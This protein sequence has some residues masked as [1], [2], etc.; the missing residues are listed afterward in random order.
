MKKRTIGD[1][2][3]SALGLGCM[4][5][6]VAY[7]PPADEADM[8]R[9]MR[10]AHDQGVTFFDTAEAY[11]PFANE[12]LVGKALAPIR[13]Q[14]VIATKF[15][16]DIDQQTG[17]RSG[18]T[19][20]RPDHVKAVADACLRRLKTDRIDLF[21]Q[22]RVDPDVPIEDVAGAV[23]ELIAAGK[24]KYFGLSEAGVQTI[25]RAHAVQKVTAVQSEYSLF[26]RGPEAELLPTLQELGIGFVPFSPLGAGFLTGK[27][28]ENTKF[29]PSDFR[30]SVPRFS[31]EARKANFA[32]VDL[33]RRI[34]D[35]KGATPAQI[36]LSWLLSQKPWIVPI[37]GTTKQ[38]RLEENL[39]AVDVDLLPEDLAEIDAALSEIE[40][41]GERLPEAALK[42]TGR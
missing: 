17:E 9:L 25:R 20:S 13:D 32:L 12:E 16:F 29:D 37:P 34:G 27:I 31:P 8:I 28:D 24:V 4:S 30:N 10:T 5:M 14:V 33:I 38:H 1:L 22:H 15:G 26:W 18:G 42:M 7:G 21:Y 19:N 40:V 2:E 3:V 6:S 35:R 41:Q 39:G 36:A 11:G 23:K